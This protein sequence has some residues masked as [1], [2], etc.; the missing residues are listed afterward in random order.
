[1]DLSAL[2]LTENQKKHLISLS[3][4]LIPGKQI[5]SISTKQ[6]T[7]TSVI[8][9]LSFDGVQIEIMPK[10]LKYNSTE[11]QSIIRNLMFMLAYTNQLD[12]SDSNMSEMSHQH[13][14][15]MEAYI[16]IYS[17]R[18]LNQ[19]RKYGVPKSYVQNQE[20]INTLKG[21]IVFPKHLL[22]N[23]F[24]QSKVYC[25]YSDFSENNDVSKSFKFVVINL[26]KLTKS[27]TN[28]SALNRCLGLLDGV[29]AEY[30]KP[31]RLD[32]ANIG[33]RDSNFLGL[34]NL[35]KMFLKKMRP[36]FSEG[37]SNKVFSLLFD[38]NEL[39]EEFIFQLLKR[40]SSRFEVDVFAQKKRRLVSAERDFCATSKWV[41]KSLFDTF[42]DILIVPK[43]GTSFIIDTKYKVISSERSHYGISN[44][45][46]YQV[47]AYRQIHSEPND[48][49]SVALLYPMSEMPL[50]REFRVN[51]H[52]STFFAWTID[53]SRNLQE[54]L[55]N[56]LDD[57][58]ELI[59]YGTEVVG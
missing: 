1:M 20:N 39:F 43:N 53:I 41:N 18:L 25:E 13:D 50:K 56:I 45:D 30:V 14:S 17:S 38:M 23:S 10:I 22:L 51:G 7:A 37:K 29:L 54:E 9:L 5:F 4:T 26:L 16:S 11:K 46:A 28:L 36:D 2:P 32:H 3:D 33:K 58:A 24:D 40:N 57:L 59:R 44:Q 35:T 48:I 27:P 42:T 6:I 55:P 49:P 19:L 21:K 31:E 47:L 12:I 34:L 52:G 15:F 8:G